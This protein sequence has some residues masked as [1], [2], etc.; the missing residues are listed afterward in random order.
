[1][2]NNTTIEGMMVLNTPRWLKEGWND[3]DF[4]I[5]FVMGGLCYQLAMRE[6]LCDRTIL[7]PCS[8]W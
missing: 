2:A 6:R 3:T 5:Y 8:S 7:V 1:M 4:S